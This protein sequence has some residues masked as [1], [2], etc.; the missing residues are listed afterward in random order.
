MRCY[1]EYKTQNMFEENINKIFDIKNL[2]DPKFWYKWSNERI[3]NISREVN[4]I[5]I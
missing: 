2:K 4:I 5:Y 3:G 1:K